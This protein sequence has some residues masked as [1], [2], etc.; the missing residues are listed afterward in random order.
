MVERRFIFY[1]IVTLFISKFL[2][3]EA[4]ANKTCKLID[5]EKFPFIEKIVKSEKS[6][7]NEIFVK[8][9]NN[10]GLIIITCM[11][12]SEIEFNEAIIKIELRDKYKEKRE[13]ISLNIAGNVVS[14]SLLKRVN[15]NC[16]VKANDFNNNLAVFITYLGKSDRLQLLFDLLSNLKYSQSHEIIKSSRIQFLSLM[17][18]IEAL[19]V[20][21]YKGAYDRNE[22]FSISETGNTI[23][24]NVEISNNSDPI[25]DYYKKWFSEIGWE[26]YRDSQK[27]TWI[28]NRLHHIWTDPKSELMSL[29]LI[30]RKGTTH[31]IR[32]NIS[33]YSFFYESIID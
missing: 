29:V 28:E 21:I 26:N 23:D 24:Y 7:K 31:S 3:K 18:N 17:R 22:K 13:D 2:F 20:P 4:Y 16:T 27:E 6:S 9:K 30:T 15:N 32:L 10:S 33:L 5:I 8:L 14:G 19:N 11:P 12:L 25:L 1:L